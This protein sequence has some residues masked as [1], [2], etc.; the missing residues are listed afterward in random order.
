METG[1][2][3]VLIKGWV[4]MRSLVNFAKGQTTLQNRP[5]MLINKSWKELQIWEACMGFQ[6]YH[7]HL[8][9]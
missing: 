6:G 8:L 3:H 4:N 7:L 5:Q 1:I 2:M 9:Y